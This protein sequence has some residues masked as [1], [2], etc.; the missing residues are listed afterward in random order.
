MTSRYHSHISS[1]YANGLVGPI[2]IDGPASGDYDIDLGV[3]PISDWYYNSA[4]SLL[5]RVFNANSPFVP[6]QPGSPPPSDNILFNG[7]NINPYGGS[8]GNYAKVAFTPGKRHRLRLIN[9]SVDNT[10]TV[11]IVG[12]SMTIIATDFV[13]VQPYPADSVYLSVGQRLDVMIDANQE[14]GTYWLN[15]TFSSANVCGSSTNKY[16]AAIV[17]YDGAPWWLPSDPGSPPRDSYCADDISPIPVISNKPPVAF[18]TAN[19]ADT[20]NVSLA[21]NTTVSKVYW[22]VNGSA[23]DIMWDKPTL[24]YVLDGNRS[25]PKQSN[26]I[27]LSSKSEVRALPP[28]YSLSPHPRPNT[29]PVDALLWTYWLELTDDS[30]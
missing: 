22:Q 7:T 2:H 4:D 14:I 27:E 13:P 23:I 30:M 25:F 21:V 24:Q 20:L 9:T 17:Q 5:D 19:P 1:Q 12:H 8:G 28:T 18:F 16:P 29:S 10:F 6:G 11:S 26:I 15:A 3:F